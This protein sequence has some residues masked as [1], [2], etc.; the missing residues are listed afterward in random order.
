MSGAVQPASSIRCLISATFAAASGTF[1]VTR[2]ISDPASANSMHCCAV[3][4]ASAVS[5]IVIDWTTTGAPPPTWTWP[6]FTPTV[7]CSLTSC[8][9]VPMIA[10]AFARSGA[11]AQLRR[12]GR[13]LRSKPS[14]YATRADGRVASTASAE[15]ERS[16]KAIRVHE[17]G[18][19]DVMKLEEIP[20]PVA[21]P[22]DVVV[23]VRAAGVNPVDAYMHTG[24]Y[25]RK[26]LL[27][28]TPGQDGAG[29]IV[30]GRRR[31]QG[32]Q[33]RG[34]RV[35]LRR[36]QHDRRRRHLRGARALRPV[37]A[38]PAARARVVRVRAPR[39][40]S[41]TAPRIARSSSAPARSPAKPC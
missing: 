29:E 31:R 17:F 21:G 15:R 41:R 12:A 4:R 5:V 34:P 19:P 1:T 39:S 13:A 28:Y 16:M 8:M 38:A 33:G 7:L 23:R 20:D 37:A 30:V 35:R 36:R 27:P 6:T 18:G 11:S 3:A 32:F 40:A 2:T 14:R 22:G 24:T 10:S 26:P 9:E 25:A